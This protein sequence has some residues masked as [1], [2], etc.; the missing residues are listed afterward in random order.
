MLGSPIQGVRLI[1]SALISFTDGRYSNDSVGRNSKS[2][3]SPILFRLLTSVTI[4]GLIL[5]IVGINDSTPSTNKT[6]VSSYKVDA[7][8]EVGVILFVLAWACLSLLLAVVAMHMS[9]VDSGEKR[10]VLAVAISVP[11]ILVRLCYSLLGDFTHHNHFNP[12]TGS[13]TIYLCMAVFMEFAVVIT[14]LAIGFTLQ[15]IPRSALASPVGTVRQSQQAVEPDGSLDTISPN[16][17]QSPRATDTRNIVPWMVT[18]K[19]RGMRQMK[20]GPIHT[21]IGLAM[22][23]HAKLSTVET[24]QRQS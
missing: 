20:G 7:K 18:R 4:V 3:V 6:S 24:Q 5:C 1:H 23:H 11:F 16:Y 22:D 19:E 10:L 13:V 8:T 12:L 14:C 2:A 9:F 21:L 17:L 15:V